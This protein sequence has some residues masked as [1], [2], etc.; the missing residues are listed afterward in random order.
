[1]RIAIKTR[2][3]FAA[4]FALSL[5]FC[6]GQT[7]PVNFSFVGADTPVWDFSGSFQISQNMQGAGGQDVPLSYTIA[8]T[9]DATGRLQGSDWTF[10]GV[11]N[12]TVAAHYVVSGRVSGGGTATKVTLVVR[13]SGEDTIAGVL[14]PFNLV[15]KYDLHVFGGALVGTS[16]GSARFFKLGSAT[17][18]DSVSLP[19]APGMDG[20]WTL[21]LNIVALKKLAGSASITL[22]NGRILPATLSGSFA[23][24]RSSVRLTAFNDGKGSRLNLIFFENATAPDSLQGR[25]LGQ[26]VRKP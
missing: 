8:I 12:D 4:L 5:Q 11:G 10:L 3:L 25:I 13:L 6:F 17:I 15:I 7:S 1:M 22:S 2:W 9:H 19:L 23:S 26:T 20:S 16:R 24:G 18:K 14:T 21:Q